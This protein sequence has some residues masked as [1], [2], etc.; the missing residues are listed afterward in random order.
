MSMTRSA[1]CISI[2][3]VI[4]V[5]HHKVCGLSGFLRS[6]AHSKISRT[7]STT[8]NGAN[9]D[10]PLKASG[11][12]S[13]TSRQS[14]TLPS[15]R[16]PHVTAACRYGRYAGLCQDACFCVPGRQSFFWMRSPASWSRSRF[17]TPRRSSSVCPLSRDSTPG[18]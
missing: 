7:T 5:R 8:S 18:T 10:C 11:S 9:G 16:R 2:L 3:P 4:L 6:T 13:A 17:L 15:P 1:R 12:L 14:A